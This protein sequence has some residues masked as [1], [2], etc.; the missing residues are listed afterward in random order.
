MT[1]DAPN[2]RIESLDQFRGYTVLGMFLVNFVGSF[3]AV[4]DALP[5]LKHHH[6]YLSYADTLMPHF[7]FAVGFAFRLTFQNAAAAGKVSPYA[8]SVKRSLALLLVAFVIYPL[9]DRMKSW[10]EWEAGRMEILLHRE[11][12]HNL[13]QTLAHIALA[14]LWVLP[15]IAAGPRVRFGYAV[16]S[17][18]LHLGLSYWFNYTWSNTQPNSI[19][20]GPLGFLTWSVP[21]LAGTLAHDAYQGGPLNAL[22]KC[23]LWGIALIVLGYGLDCLRLGPRSKP[24][25]L[26]FAWA[27]PPFLYVPVNP[28]DW[29]LFTVSQR[30]GSITYLVYGTGFSL[31]VYALFIML[32]DMKGFR[33]GI[34][35][36][37]G[38]NALAAYIVHIL[39]GQAVKPYVPQ[40]APLWYVFAAFACFLAICYAI[41]RYLERHRLYLRL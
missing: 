27:A 2:S 3:H 32:S 40:D 25:A 14:S 26:S 35:R 38:A 39:V 15:V 6:T 10:S 17:G 5:V 31:V 33:L 8:K 4:R 11:F 19:D 9:D 12:K 28:P 22:R 7:L 37:L 36:T 30:A 34:F 23:L 21:L 18:L 20:G 13:F 1:K 16:F 24:E 29:N 41:M